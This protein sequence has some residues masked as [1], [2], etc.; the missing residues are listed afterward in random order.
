MV[1]DSLLFGAAVQ[2]PQDVSGQ[3]A[4]TVQV[5]LVGWHGVRAKG[6]KAIKASRTGSCLTEAPSFLL[7]I[8]SCPE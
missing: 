1:Q 6:A 7:L 5:G 2:M 4:R 3:K 8:Y